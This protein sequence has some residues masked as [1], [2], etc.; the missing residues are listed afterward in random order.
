L[1]VNAK[2]AEGKT[3]LHL[4]VSNQNAR[5]TSLLLCHPQLDLSVR[6]KQGLTPF[7]AALTCRNNKAAQAILDRMPSAAEQYDNKGLNFL[8]VAVK[9]N[10][11]ESVLFLLSIN[12][13]PNSKVRDSSLSTPL[14][15]SCSVSN[16]GENKSV[17]SGNF[18]HEIKSI[19]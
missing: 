10:D 4:A 17:C 5:I 8:H 3:P 11:L 12:V 19:L 15:L 9:R 14:H 16:P 2:D 18:H 13:D 6:D 1:Q 7:A